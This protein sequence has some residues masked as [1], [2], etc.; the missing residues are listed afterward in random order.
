[1]TLDDFLFYFPGF[2]SVPI[3]LIGFVLAWVVW[4]LVADWRK[5]EK[6]KGVEN[7]KKM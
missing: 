1:M 2:L 5:G 7:S 6:A 3:I 4:R